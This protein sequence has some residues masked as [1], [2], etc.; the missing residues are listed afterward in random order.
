M[1][2][3]HVVSAV[4]TVM[5]LWALF[6][7]AAGTAEDRCK[8]QAVGRTPVGGPGGDWTCC[9]YCESGFAGRNGYA[10]ALGPRNHVTPGQRCNARQTRTPLT[11]H[12]V[13]DLLDDMLTYSRRSHLMVGR[14]EEKQDVFEAEMITRESGTL[15]DHILVDK[16]TAMMCLID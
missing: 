6:G 16:E 3:K 13:R 10:L 7:A 15:A 9:P 8:G 11:M 5:C 12:T 4:L 14:I 1:Q 2:A